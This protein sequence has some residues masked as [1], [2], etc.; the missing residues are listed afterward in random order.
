MRINDR[1][2]YKLGLLIKPLI[3]LQFRVNNQ[4]FSGHDEDSPDTMF[5]IFMTKIMVAV[6]KILGKLVLAKS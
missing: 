1:Y 4:I 2:Y 3:F 5:R 6:D